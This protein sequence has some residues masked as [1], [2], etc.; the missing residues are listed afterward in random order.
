MKF[1]YLIVG[2]GLSGSTCARLLAEQNY[3]ICI[4]DSRH[5]IGGNCYDRFNEEGIFIHEY[6]P[7]IFHTNNKSVW[8]FLQRFTIFVPY[9]HIAKVFL[10]EIGLYVDFP[11]NRNTIK[12]LNIPKNEYTYEFSDP[13]NA[14]TYLYSTM[15]KTI[16]NLIYKDYSAKQWGVPLDQLESNVVSRVC[17]IDDNCEYYFRNKWQG[18][19]KYGYTSMIQNM[20]NHPNIQL[21]LG[22]DYFD[23]GGRK[24]KIFKTNKTIVTGCVD[25]FF[26][27]E[28]GQLEYIK[29]EFKFKTFPVYQHQEYAQVNYPSKDIPYTRSVEYKLMT[30]QEHSNTTVSYE[31][32]NSQKSPILCYPK[33]TTE[34]NQRY[35]KYLKC[36]VSKQRK[37]YFL[38]R[39]GSFKYFNMDA[40]VYQ[41]MR[42]CR[43]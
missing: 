5:H 10:P 26:D 24:Q 21:F 34:N 27:Y 32:P 23:F 12:Q 29:T 14:E 36:N 41:A 3:K 30:G 40:A 16:T 4:I 37:F 13:T 6:G 25:Q 20:L 43:C 28:F 17:L 22:V 8:D 7:H 1:D 42:F 2:C 11:P 38:G 39:L 18:L 33:L 9:Y 31:Y 15:G 35:E 19:P